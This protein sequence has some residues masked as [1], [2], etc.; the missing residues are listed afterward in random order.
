MY[1]KFFI[2]FTLQGVISTHAVRDISYCTAD[3]EDK[4][5]FA[6]ITK[7]RQASVNYSHVFMAPS[8][9]RTL[10]VMG[11]VSGCGLCLH[12]CINTYK[13]PFLILI[14]LSN[15]RKLLKKFD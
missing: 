2:T 9:V 7:D 6:Y 4:R 1:I 10:E 15:Y 3:R 12:V 5:V 13:N 11:R 8:K 14:L